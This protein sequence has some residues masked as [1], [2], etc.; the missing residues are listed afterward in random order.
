VNS[1]AH[2][3]QRLVAAC[4]ALALWGFDTVYALKSVERVEAL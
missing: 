3:K 4:R 1:G 2:R